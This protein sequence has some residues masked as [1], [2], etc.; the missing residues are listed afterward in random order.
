[1]AADGQRHSCEV[2]GSPLPRTGR[3]SLTMKVRLPACAPGTPPDTGA[4]IIMGCRCPSC[5]SAAWGC[6]HV[7]SAAAATCSDGRLVVSS[8]AQAGN[9]LARAI[10]PP[11]PALELCHSAKS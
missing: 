4:S 8:M 5:A 10:L 1:M 6:N 2:C 11:T 9:F 3:L 7:S